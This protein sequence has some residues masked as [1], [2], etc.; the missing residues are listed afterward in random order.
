[1]R[2]SSNESTVSARIIKIAVVA[3]ALGMIMILIA[4]GSSL[5]LQ[6]EIKN[7]TIALSG[8]L[9]IAPFENNN[10][11]ISIRPIDTIELQ[12]N[13]WEDKSKI[14]SSISLYCK[15]GCC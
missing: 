11:T 1:M 10:S 14:C 12:K 9:R 13:K 7:K 4:M 15:R 8:D 5:G 3:I 6:N 2:S